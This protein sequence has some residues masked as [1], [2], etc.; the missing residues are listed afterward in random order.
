MKDFVD[1]LDPELVPALASA[2]ATDLS[3][4]LPK[5]REA[6]RRANEPLLAALP[7]VPDV[8]ATDV[9]AG[10]V[11]VRIYS[12]HDRVA[13]TPG[14]VWIHGGGMVFGSVD[15][16]DYMCRTWAR[17]LGCVIASVDYRLAPEHQYP[18]HVEDAFT[19]LEWVATNVEQLGI[20]PSRIV[21]GGASAGGGIAAG[22]ALLA[23]D[24]GL[25]PALAA[26]MLV[27][28]MI[29]DRDA[30]PSTQEI[31]ERRVW[32]RESNRHGWRAYLGERAGT[33]DVPIYAAPARASVD[34][35]RGLPSTYMDV[36]ELDPFRDEDIAYATR[37]LQAGVPCELHVTPGVWHASESTVIDAES[38]RRIRGYRSDWMRR[39]LVT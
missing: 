16:D 39:H 38:S 1:R 21:L 33:D 7:E 20:G 35:L 22:T 6:L 25:T 29:D 14:L 3:G 26:Q 8:K 19:A 17:R 27:F 5:L 31:T 30:T 15:G 18:A 4:D 37:L 13:P 23:R 24:R 12:R 11:P 36:G 10:D 28:P 2:P 32:N 9:H 34:E